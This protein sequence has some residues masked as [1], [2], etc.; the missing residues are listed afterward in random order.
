[1]R[2]NAGVLCG[3]EIICSHCT[4][5]SANCYIA[6]LLRAVE[7]LVVLQREVA[8]FDDIFGLALVRHWV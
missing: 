4:Y 3:L 6:Y 5:Y 2:I 7:V 1:M 8:I